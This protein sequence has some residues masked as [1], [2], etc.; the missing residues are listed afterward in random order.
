MADADSKTIW[1]LIDRGRVRAATYAPKTKN[2]RQLVASMIHQVFDR[3]A[4]TGL[5][6]KGQI[7]SVLLVAAWFRKFPQERE[8]LI[9]KEN[10][11]EICG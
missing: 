11:L 2:Q 5:L 3:K 7:D 8:L 6:P 4:D 9:T 10:A 1:Y